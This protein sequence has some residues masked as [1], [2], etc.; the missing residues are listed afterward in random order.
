[1]TDFETHPVGTAK[2]LESAIAALEKLAS[3]DAQ[4]IA[5]TALRANWRDLEAHKL[6]LQEIAKHDVQGWAQMALAEVR[7]G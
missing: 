4:K 3:C 7:N 2:K 5:L 6:A 1:M